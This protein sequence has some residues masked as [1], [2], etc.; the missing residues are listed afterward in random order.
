MDMSGSVTARAE[1]NE[2]FFGIISELAAWADVVDL[3]ISRCAAILT[4]PPIAS[5]HLAREMAIRLG[6][7][8]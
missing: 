2:V 1:R 8:P 3:K 4:A 5:K 7:K 6:F